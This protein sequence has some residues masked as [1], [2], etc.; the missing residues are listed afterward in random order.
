MPALMTGSRPARPLRQL[1]L[2]LVRLFSPRSADQGA[3][4]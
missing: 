2:S 3:A 4:G 1:Q